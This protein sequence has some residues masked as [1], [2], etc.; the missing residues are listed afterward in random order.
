MQGMRASQLRRTMAALAALALLVA[1]APLAGAQA[2]GEA[3]PKPRL[4]VGGE[5]EIEVEPDRAVVVIGVEARGKNAGQAQAEA[6]RQMRGLRDALRRSNVP[7]EDIRSRNLQLRP[8]YEYKDG[9]RTFLGYLAGHDLEVQVD[10]LAI[11]GDLLDAGVKQGAT[12]IHGVRFE[13]ADQEDVLR[14]ALA[15]AVKVAEGRA[16]AMAQGAGVKLGRLL[17]LTTRSSAP[18]PVMKAEAAMMRAA[19]SDAGTEVNPGT[20]VVRAEVEAAYAIGD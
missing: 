12:V 11:L 16:A 15:E 3:D 5:A 8:E 4:T 14:Q 19:A 17:S 13:L 18:V 10:D 9:G 20:I 2:E 1:L 6:A 7:D